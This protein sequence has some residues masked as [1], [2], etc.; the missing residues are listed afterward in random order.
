MVCKLKELRTKIKR[1]FSDAD[2][3]KMLD[4]LNEMPLDSASVGQ[5]PSRDRKSVV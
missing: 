4:G 2:T 3:H 5:K 1:I